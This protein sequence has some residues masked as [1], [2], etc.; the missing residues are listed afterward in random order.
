VTWLDGRDPANVQSA[1]RPTLATVLNLYLKR[2]NAGTSDLEQLKPITT[3][4]VTT[5]DGPRRFGDCRAADVTREI[6]ESFRLQRPKVAGNR[7]LALLRAMFKW[8]VMDGLVPRSPFR[9]GDVCVVRLA[10]EEA[11]TRRLQPGEADRLVQASRGLRPLIVAALETG[12]RLG[13][14][15]TLQWHQV[16]VD[17]SLPA[18]K[19]KAKKPRRVPISS[20]LRTD[21]RIVAG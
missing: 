15:L 3:P 12:C 19:T 17:L 7:N 16:G 10:R 21:A 6:L 8:A 13:E 1:D 9:I 11:R 20:V 14:L 2:P 5:P 4:T 18:G